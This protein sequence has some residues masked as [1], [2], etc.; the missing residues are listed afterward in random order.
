MSAGHAQT[1]ERDHAV[2]GGEKA[3]AVVWF[4]FRPIPVSLSG[5]AP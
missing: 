3:K 2:L 1:R 5:R 4:S